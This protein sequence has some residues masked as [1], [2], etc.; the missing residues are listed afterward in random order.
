MNYILLIV[1]T[2][3]AFSTHLLAQTSISN[4]IDGI[5]HS[6]ELRFGAVRTKDESGTKLTT[7]SMGGKV[8]LETKPI[9]GISLVGT[10]FTTNPIFGKR[11]DGMFL[12]SHQE[13]YSIAG[14]SYLKANFA[15]TIIKAG[16]QIIDTPYAD[17]DDIGIIPN[18]FEGYSLVNSDAEGTTVILALLDKWSGIDAP[19]PEKFTKMQSSKDAVFTAG[20]IIKGQ[21]NTTLQA[22]HYKLDNANFNYGEISYEADTFNMAIQYTDQDDSNRA[23]GISLGGRVDNLNITIAYNSVDGRV[24]NGFGGGP[25]FTSAEDHTIADVKDQKAKMYGAEYNLDKITLGA[26][27]V[28]LDKGEDETDYIASFQVNKN[29]TLDLIYSDMYDDGNIVRFFANYQF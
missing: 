16:R 3:I 13:G 19:T 12:N 14:E 8:S 10:L 20:I 22:W 27:H 9:S 21:E 26:T 1:V 23:Y 28:D 24:S 7:L 4:A 25:F 29:H 2:I 15:K 5:E 17:S 11:E 6:G 18:T